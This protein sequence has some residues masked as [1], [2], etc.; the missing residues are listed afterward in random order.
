MAHSFDA[1]MS[2]PSPD[3]A[4]SATGT[5]YRRDQFPPAPKSVR[6]VTLS[7]DA[8]EP[9]GVAASGS[10]PKESSGCALAKRAAAVWLAI[11]ALCVA[12]VLVWAVLRTAWN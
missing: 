9:K 7:R 10:L 2:T 12:A 8:S 1:P 11:A 4:R 3:A 6:I 5:R